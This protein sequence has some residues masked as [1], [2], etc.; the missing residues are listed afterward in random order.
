MVASLTVRGNSAVVGVP[1][2][3]RT[4][5]TVG[6]QGPQRIRRHVFCSVLKGWICAP[7]LDKDDIRLHSGWPEHSLGCECFVPDKKDRFRI[8]K[9]LPPKKK[10]IFSVKSDK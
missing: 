1:F 2:I 10:D 7:P 8:L 5:I 3:T 9:D 6:Y 4:F